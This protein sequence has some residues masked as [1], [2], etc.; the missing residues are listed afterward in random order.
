MTVETDLDRAQYATNAT[1]GPWT[2]PFYFLDESELAITYT[3]AAGVDT[4]LVLDVDYTVAGAGD[5]DGGTVLTTQ[6]YATGGKLV[7]LRDVAFVQATEYQDGDAF[8]TKTHERALD[9]LTMIAQ[10]LREMFGRAIAFPASYSGSTNVGDLA[11]R[12]GK[13][14]GF[15]AVTGVITYVTAS[16]G[17]ALELAAQSFRG[18]DSGSPTRIH[19]LCVSPSSRST[20]SRR[21]KSTAFPV[22][23]SSIIAQ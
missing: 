21:S 6:A 14:L 3:N 1:T 19:A 12:A 2:V 8:P 11:T 9:R 7:I 5:E 22:R 15:D 10:Q 17:S 16:V 20:C 23:K 4:L 13:L 18:R